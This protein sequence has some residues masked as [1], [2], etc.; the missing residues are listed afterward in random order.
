MIHTIS[1]TAL[2]FGFIAVILPMNNPVNPYAATR[3][4]IA[5][6]AILFAISLELSNVILEWLT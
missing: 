4:N 6:M 5:I 3:L 2:L 1:L